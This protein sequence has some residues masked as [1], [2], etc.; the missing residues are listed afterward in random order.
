MAKPVAYRVF[1]P[2]DAREELKQRIEDAPVEHAEA[3]LS[4]YRLL[5]QAHR[6]GVLEMLRGA[7]AAE[8]TVISNVVEALSKP[9]MMNALRNLLV[10]GKVMGSIDPEKLQKTIGGEEG[11]DHAPPSIFTLLSCMNTGD[12][13]RGLH[14]AIGMLAAFGAAARPQKK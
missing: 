11:K 8:D 2:P 7:M 13:R 6:S 10:L 5:E 12:A 3:V 1:T 4:G 9:E 14:A